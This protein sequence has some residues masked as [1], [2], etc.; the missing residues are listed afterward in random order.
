MSPP[1][2][3][4]LLDPLHPLQLPGLPTEQGALDRLPIQGDL[5]AAAAGAGRGGGV[6]AASEYHLHA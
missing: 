2:R 3:T 4:L 1:R 5:V 6:A